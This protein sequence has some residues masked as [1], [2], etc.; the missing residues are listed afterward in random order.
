MESCNR[1]IRRN[2]LRP[3]GYE[4]TDYTEINALREEIRRGYYRVERPQATP[5]WDRDIDDSIETPAPHN[6]PM[7]EVRCNECFETFTTPNREGG[8]LQC[9]HCHAAPTD[10]SR[11]AY[12]A[13][14]VK[15]MWGADFAI[16]DCP[17]PECGKLNRA[18]FVPP[19]QSLG[20]PL[21]PNSRRCGRRVSST[22][23]MPLLR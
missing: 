23:E 4:I 14:L 13:E 19:R 2:R 15:P 21:R 1:G 11:H 6:E 18:V 9:P 5:Y 7:L 10:E 22:P 17:C 12:P 16:V 8:S 3:E 20:E